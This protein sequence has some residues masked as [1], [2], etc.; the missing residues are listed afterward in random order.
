MKAAIINNKSKRTI[1]M[2]P[3]R[4]EKEFNSTINN[5]KKFEFEGI[6]YECTIMHERFWNA[7]SKDIIHIF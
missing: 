7:I 4:Y 1:I 6:K 2:T 5:G 3:E